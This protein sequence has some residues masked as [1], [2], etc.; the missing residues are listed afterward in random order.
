MEPMGNCMICDLYAVIDQ[1][2]DDG[3]DFVA[4]LVST[5][6][7]RGHGFH[8]LMILAGTYRSR[9]TA[10]PKQHAD[11]DVMVRWPGD[12]VVRR[13]DVA[14]EELGPDTFGR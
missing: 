8:N 12:E 1:H 9:R 13:D 2:G 4:D 5:L 14:D 7:P 3:S 6:P 11:G 10:G